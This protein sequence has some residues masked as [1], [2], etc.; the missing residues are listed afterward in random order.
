[1]P[2]PPLGPPSGHS[3]APPSAASPPSGTERTTPPVRTASALSAAQAAARDSALNL[4]WN[5]WLS[6]VKMRLACGVRESGPDLARPGPLTPVPGIL[7]LAL[8]GITRHPE[9]ASARH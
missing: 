2:H 1:M 4:M 6:R 7:R 8:T 3:S 5:E 9:S